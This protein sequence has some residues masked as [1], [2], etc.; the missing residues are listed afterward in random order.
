[1][2]KQE[3]EKLIST[4]E[5]QLFPSYIGG[6]GNV[7]FAD[8]VGGG[9]RYEFDIAHRVWNATGVIVPSEAVCPDGSESPCADCPMSGD[10]CARYME[11]IDKS[12]PQERF[13]LASRPDM[14]RAGAFSYR[15]GGF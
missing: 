2:E 8:P 11:S 12:E 7:L 10:E 3:M 15:E 13:S 1:M 9:E 14:E 4:G 5:Y 6:R